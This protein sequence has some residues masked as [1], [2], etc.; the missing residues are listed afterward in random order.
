MTKRSR[1]LVLLICTPLVAFVI[2]GGVLGRASA[3][4][5]DASQH[6][7]VFED[8]VSLILN[9]YVEEVD[10]EKV[11]DGAL[12][13]LA[14]GLD[15][16]SA[17]LQPADVRA[18]E[19]QPT[20]PGG[21][22]GLS[23]TR[24][25]YL[26]VIAARDG[27]AA[28][29][30]GLRPGDYVRAIDG[31]P[32]RDMSVFDGAKL[33]AGAPG[34]KVSLVVIRGN[35]ADPHTIDLV[36]EKPSYAQCLGSTS[37][38][39][40]QY[41]LISYGVPGPVL[42]LR[43]ASFGPNIVEQ[44]QKELAVHHEPPSKLIVDIRN[45][46]EGRLEAGLD[47]A[48]LFVPSGSLA[49]RASRKGDKSPIEARA[50]DGSITAPTAVLINAGTSGAAELFAA[51][52]AGNKRAELIGER[53]HGRAGLQK[54]VP[55]PG[56]HGLWLTYATYLT[57]AGEAI[58]EKGLPP[59]VDVEEPDVEFGA[60]PDPAKGDPILDKAL[61]KLGVKRA[62]KAEGAETK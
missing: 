34:T 33:L 46:A 30:V 2:V 17:F 31:R 24:Q 23:L 44:V 60:A 53:T 27:S 7:R 18:I 36:R 11:M 9:N 45:T 59:S 40:G 8:V 26:R 39:A 52:L 5:Q 4:S 32:T 37:C 28:A 25:Y 54:L 29:R 6:L 62:E 61:E 58:H 20:P 22:V 19:S 41:Q 14:D 1:V 15:A 12:R 10:V 3:A 51:A 47:V 48:R 42:V 49:I 43:I 56:D 50:G 55:L 38:P 13:G 35:A 57:P 16:D 21:D